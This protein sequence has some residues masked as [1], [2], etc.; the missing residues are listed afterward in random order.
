MDLRSAVCLFVCVFR[1]LD[2]LIDVV[3]LSVRSRTQR[4]SFA[5]DGSEMEISHRGRWSREKSFSI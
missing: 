3:N 1:M 4:E 2:I 5:V